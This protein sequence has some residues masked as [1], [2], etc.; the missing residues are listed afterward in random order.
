MARTRWK[1][2]IIRRIF[3]SRTVCV[4]AAMGMAAG[5][6]YAVFQARA[7]DSD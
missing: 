4:V 6:P 7:N 5:L 1:Q 3:L 2:E